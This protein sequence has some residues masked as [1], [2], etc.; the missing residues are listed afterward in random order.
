MSKTDIELT[1]RE[2]AAIMPHYP[3]G[4]VVFT[5]PCGGTANAGVAVITQQ[6]QFFLKRRNPRYCKPEAII[7]DHHVVKS[8]ARAGLP[9]P[10]VIR[11]I[12]G[13]RWLEHEGHIYEMF[14]FVDGDVVETPT[15]PQL[16]AAGEML[17]RLHQ[18]TEMLQPPGA[19]AFGRFWGPAR[20]LGLLRPFVDRVTA[21]RL[22]SLSGV[23]PE[24]AQAQFQALVSEVERV[25]R[26]LPDSAYAALPH[27]VI[28]G[29][30]HPANIKFRGAT[31]SGIFD[32][33]WF[34]RQ[35]RMVD[36]ADGMLFFCGVRPHVE[37]TGD[38]WSL[39][40]TPE[41]QLDRMRA[42]MTGYGSRIRPAAGELQALPELMAVRW[43]YARADAADRKIDEVD[44]VRF[45]LRDVLSPLEWIA[46]H[47]VRLAE[48]GWWE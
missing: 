42:F 41:L 21:G 1:E 18:T 13:S 7:Y 43:V 29:D 5:R 25:A 32:F 45:I 23:T 19:K 46:E 10:R 16:V 40:R 2:I 28:H 35:P 22:G 15:E 48:A 26:A 31:V 47:R 9:C 24:T 30:W 12:P 27:A 11:T 4:P 38:I 17:A 37:G 14:E 8:L 34:D 3:V 6:G 44:Q 36:V 33:D 39:T 20:A